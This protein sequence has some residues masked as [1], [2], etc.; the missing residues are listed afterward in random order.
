M[1]FLDYL[2]EFEEK[3]QT[4]LT[5]PNDE[6]MGGVGEFGGGRFRGPESPRGIKRIDEY[7]EQRGKGP[8]DIPGSYWDN[9]EKRFRGILYATKFNNDPKEWHTKSL[10]LASEKEPCKVVEVYISNNCKYV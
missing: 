9:I 6:D 3:S 8:H 7:Q 4:K 10:R 5:T 2:N 1:S